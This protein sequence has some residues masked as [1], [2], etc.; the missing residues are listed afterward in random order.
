MTPWQQIAFDDPITDS[1]AFTELNTVGAKFGR[2]AGDWR[3]VVIVD[4]TEGIIEAWPCWH[5]SVV[6]GEFIRGVARPALPL[7]AWSRLR[8]RFAQRLIR[9]HLAG[10]GDPLSE[11]IAL[12]GQLIKRAAETNRAPP[13]G[14][15]G[16]R[17]MTVD[18]VRECFAAQAGVV[19]RLNPT[20]GMLNG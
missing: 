9:K 1:A 8:M 19:A 14:L 11:S 4:A 2:Y 15:A 17:R 10:V 6:Y 3:V 20:F 12:P 5:V 18:E 13:C 16:R 7:A